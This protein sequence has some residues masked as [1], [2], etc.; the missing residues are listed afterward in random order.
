MESLLLNFLPV[1]LV[2]KICYEHK[3]IEHPLSIIMKPVIKE[4]KESRICKKFCL[5]DNSEDWVSWL[6]QLY[7]NKLRYERYMRNE[8]KESIKLPWD[9][10]IRYFE[11]YTFD[12]FY[13]YDYAGPGPYTD[14]W[15]IM[16]VKVEDFDEDLEEHVMTDKKSIKRCNDEG[17]HC[18]YLREWNEESEQTIRIEV[19]DFDEELDEF[20]EDDILGMENC[21]NG[22]WKGTFQIREWDE[23]VKPEFEI[24]ILIN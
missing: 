15:E 19:N 1:E 3:G 18:F 24:F 9:Y 22:E 16:E 10:E 23:F 5:E 7:L 14:N 4:V 2:S 13:Q 12:N 8:N 21:N 6:L 20:V 17:Y 11:P